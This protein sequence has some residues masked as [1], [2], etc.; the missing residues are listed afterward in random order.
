MIDDLGP[1]PQAPFPGPIEA[2]DRAGG[3]ERV[4]CGN[5]ARLREHPQRKGQAAVG[6]EVDR[7]VGILLQ[8]TVALEI[9]GELRQVRR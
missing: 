3:I 2:I 7:A 1:R 6:Q 9:G 5:D 8:G 4:W